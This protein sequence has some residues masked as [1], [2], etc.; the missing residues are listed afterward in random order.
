MIIQKICVNISETMKKDNSVEEYEMSEEYYDC[1]E[2]RGKR[3]C[4]VDYRMRN[5]ENDRGYLV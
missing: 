5:M 4:G 3:E 1:E 2:K